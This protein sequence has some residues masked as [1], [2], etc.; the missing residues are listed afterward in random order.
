VAL[1]RIQSRIIQELVKLGALSDE[2]ASSIVNSDKDY[3]GEAIEKFLSEEHK[4]GAEMLLIAR[5]RAFDLHPFNAKNF[6]VNEFTF[7]K[8]DKDF[9]GEHKVLPIGVVG[10][11]FV[12]A[13]DSPFKLQLTNLIQQKTRMNVV[14]LLA[15]DSVLDEK[16]KDPETVQIPV[17]FTDVVEQLGLDVDI[18]DKALEE[19]GG[20]EESAPVIQLTNRVIEDAYY[21]GA[22]DIH[23]EPGEKEARIRVRIDGNCVEKLRIPLKVCNSMVARIKVM[24]NLDI[25]EKRIPQDGRI[26]YKQFNRK[27]IDIDLRVA[28]APLNHGEGVV[29]RILDKQKSTLPLTAL[30]YSEWNLKRYRELIE[31]PYGMILHCGPTGSGKSMTLY[32]ALNEINTPDINIRT[33]EDPIEYTLPGLCQMQMHRKIGLTFAAAL[34]AFLRQDPDIILVGEIRDIETAQIAVE[35]ALTG[36][37]LF[38]TLHTNDAPSAVARLTDMK[39]EPFMISASLICVCAQRLL[40]RL[41]K[42]S[43]ELYNPEGNE[44]EILQTALEWVGPIYR[45][46]ATSG[47]NAASGGYKGRVGVHELMVTNEELV[48]AINEG[49][50]TVVLKKIAMRTGMKTLHQDTM[51]KVKEGVTSMAEALST[52]PRDMEAYV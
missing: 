13:L 24:S 30:G 22:S 2:V 45:A 38:S 21:S 28:T 49:V 47:P 35:A 40:R 32:S 14:V 17:G 51:L 50:E 9:C 27:N 5:A 20:G 52:V 31:R 11:Y 3:S 19:D 34:R 8:L 44:A 6:V 26:V 37:L 4:V 46:N 43:K 7:E 12:V 36:H 10:D 1:G 16:L 39:I 29:M 41:C 42:V 25:A 18:E 48:K 15:L 33:A 23:I